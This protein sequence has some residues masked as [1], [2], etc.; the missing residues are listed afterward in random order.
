MS[1]WLCGG[2]FAIASSSPVWAS[3]GRQTITGRSRRIRVC[4]IC[5][6]RHNDCVV[7]F[8]PNVL[9]GVCAANYALVVKEEAGLFSLGIVPQHVD[10]FLLR[11]V[12]KAT[13][14]GDGIENRRG[15]REWIRP[16]LRDAAEDVK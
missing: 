12:L 2:A 6:S 14:D 9:F 4:I 13:R 8:Q 3:A 1:D 15:R 5:S 16:R 10:A 7:R 11:E